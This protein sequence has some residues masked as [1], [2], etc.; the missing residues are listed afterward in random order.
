MLQ[1]IFFRQNLSGLSYAFDKRR[2]KP[3]LLN[4][5][6]ADESRGRRRICGNPAFKPASPGWRKPLPLRKLSCGVQF[7]ALIAPMHDVAAGEIGGAL[8]GLPGCIHDVHRVFGSP[9]QL[10]LVRRQSAMQIKL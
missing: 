9:A 2:A 8:P 6:R 10:H 3:A 4:R 7:A 5:K 1:K